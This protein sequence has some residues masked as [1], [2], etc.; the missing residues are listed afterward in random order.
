M[1]FFESKILGQLA[2]FPH[3]VVRKISNRYLVMKVLQDLLFPA[4]HR[5]FPCEE[6]LMTLTGLS[7]EFVASRSYSREKQES[8]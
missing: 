2:F 6:G 5:Y 3:P 7:L 4:K 1:T 8:N